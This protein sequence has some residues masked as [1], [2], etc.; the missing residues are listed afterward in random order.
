MGL[1]FPA[2]TGG[3]AQ[4]M[5]GYQAKPPQTGRPVGDIGLGVFLARA[6]ELAE[7]Y[8]ERFRPAQFLRD[9]AAKGDT[10]PA[11]RPPVA[12]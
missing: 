1:G 2:N 11:C 5:T 7:V 8:G 9:L 6:D 4:L 3:A 12:G 10:F